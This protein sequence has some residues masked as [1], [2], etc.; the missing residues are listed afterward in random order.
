MEYMAT[1]M[2]CT[3]VAASVGFYKDVLGFAELWRY[4][5]GGMLIAAGLGMYN[6]QIILGMADPNKPK[7][8]PG[9]AFT[10]YI[11]I[12]EKSVDE[13]FEQLKGK[14]TVLQAPETKFWGDRT[15]VLADPDGYNVTFCQSVS[16]MQE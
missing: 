5:N 1:A 6:G 4:E 3:D 16:G 9:D 14:A 13:L 7:P 15:F 8:A 2:D 10:L 11:N 12:G